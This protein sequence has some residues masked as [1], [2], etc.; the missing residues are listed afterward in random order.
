M[1]SA[2][3]APSHTL[4]NHKYGTDG[5]L[6]GEGE[7]IVIRLAQVLFGPGFI[8]PSSRAIASR[9]TRRNCHHAIVLGVSLSEVPAPFVYFDVL[10]MPTRV[11]IQI[12]VYPQPAGCS[13]S[14]RPAQRLSTIAHSCPVRGVSHFTASSVTDTSAIR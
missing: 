10:P 8:L 4:V 3:P 12:P 11:T 5:H 6:P 7:I 13:P 14:P 2:S 1:S 9:V